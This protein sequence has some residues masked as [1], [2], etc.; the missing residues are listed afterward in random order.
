MSTSLARMMGSATGRIGGLSTNT[1]PSKRLR[2]WVKMSAAVAAAEQLGRVWRARVP[3]L[4]KESPG[5][6]RLAAAP[7]RVWLVPAPP[8]ACRLDSSRP[9]NSSSSR[10]LRDVRRHQHDSL[11]RHGT[12]D[13][14]V[15]DD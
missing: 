11:V 15:G 2:S 7:R 8:R 10:G 9:R 12:D 4:E 6:R 3:Q 14:E 5:R 13:S 1:R